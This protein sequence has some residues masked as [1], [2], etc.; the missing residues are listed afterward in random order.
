MTG[1]E[2]KLKKYIKNLKKIDPTPY[3]EL[4]LKQSSIKI[5]E[6]WFYSKKETKI[7]GFKIH[8]GIDFK[9]KR[10]EPVYAS[11]EGWATSTYHSFQVRNKDKS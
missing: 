7:H 6:G 1:K 2:K 10:N 11:T 3:L 5:T 9:A 8:A 4:P